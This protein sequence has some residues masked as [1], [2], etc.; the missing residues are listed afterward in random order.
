MKEET[1]DTR[2]MQRVIR[3]T[4]EQCNAQL[5]ANNLGNLDENS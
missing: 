4:F 3:T 1:T 2:E 5:D